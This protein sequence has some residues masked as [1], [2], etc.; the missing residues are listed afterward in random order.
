M[1]FAPRLR[2]LL[3]KPTPHRNLY[4]RFQKP[5]L[6]P[7]DPERRLT[8]LKK[9][10]CID[11]CTPSPPYA[12]PATRHGEAVGVA[13]EAG[14]HVATRKRCTLS[15]ASGGDVDPHLREGSTGSIGAPFMT[16][17]CGKREGGGTFEKIIHRM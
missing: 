3:K 13:R 8:Y 4:R 12:F 15:S 16:W 11:W 6:H 10:W 7:P 1:Y 5:P 14:I 9:K 2:K 17:W